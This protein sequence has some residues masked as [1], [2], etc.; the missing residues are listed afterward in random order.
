MT[1]TRINVIPLRSLDV[2]TVTPNK[3]TRSSEKSCRIWIYANRFP[4]F[5]RLRNL[6]ILQ[7]KDF[8]ITYFWGKEFNNSLWVG[9]YRKIHLSTCPQKHRW[10]PCE[11]VIC[12]LGYLGRI[13]YG[14]SNHM[15]IWKRESSR[16]GRGRM[17][18]RHPKQICFWRI[19]E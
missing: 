16:N 11:T 7:I 5:L 9:W 6:G 3:D 14:K 1:L 10:S 18:S 4:E 17:R 13:G 15:W 12:G 19:F 2:S 8:L